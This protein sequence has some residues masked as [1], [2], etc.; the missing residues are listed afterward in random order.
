MRLQGMNKDISRITRGVERCW[1]EG[2]KSNLTDQSK[3]ESEKYK[4]Q[5]LIVKQ[6]VQKWDEDIKL[7]IVRRQ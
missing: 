1:A 6:K 4:L 5:D 2:C 7:L 3:S